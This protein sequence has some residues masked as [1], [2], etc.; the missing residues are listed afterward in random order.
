MLPPYAQRRHKC[1]H[2]RAAD[3]SANYSDEEPNI[4]TCGIFC[5]NNRTR[6]QRTDRSTHTG[7]SIFRTNTD[8]D[9]NGSDVPADVPTNFVAERTTADAVYDL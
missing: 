8:A 3:I 6:H 4:S 2:N 7:Y 1:T 5:A 9:S